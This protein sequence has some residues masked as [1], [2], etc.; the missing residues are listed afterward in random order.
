MGRRTCQWPSGILVRLQAGHCQEAEMRK[1]TSSAPAHSDPLYTTHEAA[2][3]LNCSP[4]AIRRWR[5]QRRLVA[6]KV[7]RLTRYRRSTL[8]AFIQGGR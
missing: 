3:Y 5:S 7:S 6:V 2:F 8:D 4:A 1:P